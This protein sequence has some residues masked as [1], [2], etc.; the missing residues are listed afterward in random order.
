MQGLSGLFD[1]YSD[2]DRYLQKF[3]ANLAFGMVPYSSV[4]RNVANATDPTLRKAKTVSE[5]IQ[6]Q[7]PVVK[8]RLP[9][10]VDI[11]GNP[12]TF[13]GS[14]ATK[15]FTSIKT[16]TYNESPAM[17]EIERLRYSPK[18]VTENL[19]SYDK[20]TPETLFLLKKT[21]GKLFEQ[22]V[23][24]RLNYSGGDLKKMPPQIALDTLEKIDSKASEIARKRVLVSAIHPNVKKVVEAI[25]IQ[26]QLGNYD[27]VDNLNERLD[28]LLSKNIVELTPQG[29]RAV[30]RK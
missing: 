20:L 22:F 14:P 13:E 17:K 25:I 12:V 18:S 19:S 27:L 1:A 6:S 29:E 16:K 9:A 24:N 2:P 15:M 3:V 10:E 5:R 8:T 26:N 23:T 7:L 4:I 11:F 28:F 21:K 30:K